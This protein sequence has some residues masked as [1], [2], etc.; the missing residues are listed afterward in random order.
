MAACVEEVVVAGPQMA[1]QHQVGQQWSGRRVQ[2]T[3]APPATDPP[4][5][6]GS[7]QRV[8][9]VAGARSNELNSPRPERSGSPDTRSAAPAS[10]AA[11]GDGYWAR[12]RARAAS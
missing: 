12:W 2:P 9:N 4:T 10:P 11:A 1:G 3:A 5:P 7:G 6:A 8:R